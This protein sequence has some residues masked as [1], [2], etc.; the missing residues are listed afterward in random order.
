MC[1]RP[2]FTVKGADRTEPERRLPGDTTGDALVRT[3]PD[4]AAWVLPRTLEMMAQW[5]GHGADNICS[6]LCEYN[7]D[8]AI[9]TGTGFSTH[10]DAISYVASELEARRTEI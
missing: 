10:E 9:I 8:D 1:E 7:V 6:T 3:E 5:Y 2:I 4:P